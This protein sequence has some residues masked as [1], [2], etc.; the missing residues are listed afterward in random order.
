MTESAPAK[1]LRVMSGMRTTGELHIGHYFGAISNWLKLQEQ[2]E[3]FFGAMDWHA[4]TD[5]Y[6]DP[7]TMQQN[8]RSMVATWLAFGLDPARSVIFVQ[9]RVPEHL[10]LLIIF[11]NLTPMGWLERVNTWKDAEEEL[12]AKDAYN[13]GRFLYPVLQAADIAMYRGALVPV[14]QDQVAHL[15]LNREIIRRFNHLYKAK[16]PEP[17]PLLT[18]TP[19]IMGTDGRKMSKSYNNGLALIEDEKVLRSTLLK[20]PTDPSRVRRDDVGN[21]DVCPV[22]ELHKLFSSEE[23]K[24]WAREGC[25]TAGIGCADCKLGLFNHINAFMEKPRARQKELLNDPT[26]LD[27]IIEAGCDRARQDAQKTMGIVRKAMKF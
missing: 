3:C 2:Y 22:F 14:G 19:M 20:M 5:Q 25:V 17:K 12:K 1:K 7:S 9:S 18:E 11:A 4:M 27:S 24:T 21:P 6:K 10:E 15:E 23:T 16:L 13:L 8:T 26:E